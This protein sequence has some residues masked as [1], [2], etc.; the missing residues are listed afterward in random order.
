MADGDVFAALASPVRRE[1][2]DL[3][4]SRP[5][6]VNELAAEFAMQRPSISEHLRVLRDAG[7]VN[8]E[9]R[10]RERVY[11]IDPEPLQAVATWLHPYEEFW[12]DRM[13]SLRDLLD[14]GSQR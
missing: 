14:E 11:R 2:L 1:L 5:R 7:L 10:G 8:D 6:A 4:R 13:R 9:R 3:L 12:R